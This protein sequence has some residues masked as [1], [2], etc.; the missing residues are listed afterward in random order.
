[1]AFTVVS[2]LVASAARAQFEI[3]AGDSYDEEALFDTFDSD[4]LASTSARHLAHSLTAT[5]TATAMHNVMLRRIVLLAPSLQ[6]LGGDDSVFCHDVVCRARPT[7]CHDVVWHRPDTAP[8]VT[9]CGRARSLSH[10]RPRDTQAGGQPEP[11]SSSGSGPSETKMLDDDDDDGIVPSAAGPGVVRRHRN[12]GRASHYTELLVMTKSDFE[13][14]AAACA[15]P[16]RTLRKHL[17]TRS[18][19]VASL[20]AGPRSPDVSSTDNPLRATQHNATGG[21][22]GSSHVVTPHTMQAVESID[23]DE[24]AM[25]TRAGA[26]RP[27]RDDSVSSD[28]DHDRAVARLLGEN[29]VMAQQLNELA[30]RLLQQE[31]L[32]RKIEA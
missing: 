9:P 27:Q 7:M 20:A 15:I 8:S 3:V 11:G 10:A 28:Q 6:S 4:E 5:A 14:A 21:A 26:G 25:A 18:S 31:E 32:L 22:G 29:S 12:H 1:M 17:A 23:D 16:L 19:S 24:A 13:A 30:R 2:L